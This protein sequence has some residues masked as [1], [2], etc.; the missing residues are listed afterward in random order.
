MTE[1][2]APPSAAQ[3]YPGEA[4]GMRYIDALTGALNRRAFLEAV[5]IAVLGGDP[6][7]RMLAV[8]GI[9]LDDFGKI[10]QTFG[11]HVGDMV[12]IAT[13]NRITDIVRHGDMVGRWGNDEFAVLLSGL[14]DASDLDVPARKILDAV[15]QPILLPDGGT[16]TIAASM[17]SAIHP[18]DA[19]DIDTLF[20]RVELAVAT[21]H[22]RG[23]RQH[24]R[25][26]LEWEASLLDEFALQQALAGAIGRDELRLFYQPQIDLGS[27]EA[28]GAE[29]LMRWQPASG[30]MVPP[31][32]FIPIAERTGL[33]V[34]LGYWAMGRAAADIAAWKRA[35]LQPLPVSVNLSARQLVEA[36]FAERVVAI[37]DAAGVPHDLI[38]CELTETAISS[39]P[40]AAATALRTLDE[41]GFT[42]AVDDFGIGNSSLGVLQRYPIGI[43]KIDRSFVSRIAIDR[44]SETLV[45][46]INALSHE[47]GMKVVAEGVETEVQRDFV[48]HIG[49]EF[50]QGFFYDRPLP[51]DEFRARWL[52][53]ARRRAPRSRP[54]R[55]RPAAD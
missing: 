49:C 18:I 20:R 46:A 26:Q 54:A 1:D 37:V 24:Q 12:L 32:V 6:A 11:A 39:D 52:T 27:G 23:G 41:A 28:M 55:R 43:V 19:D 48:A 3:N 44:K 25:F 2:E 51:D 47:L 15:Q 36:G 5:S 4:I 35:G 40:A 38:W 45:R 53:P 29:A 8:V 17:G 9:D 31:S 33:I 13:A 34:E 10:N 21:A 42:I 14:R 7:G 22:G 30:D 16:L 50:V